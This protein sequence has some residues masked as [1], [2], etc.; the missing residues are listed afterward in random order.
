MNSSYESNHA[1]RS[2]ESSPRTSIATSGIAPIPRGIITRTE[3]TPLTTRYE[4]PKQAPRNETIPRAYPTSSR[5]EATASRAP[6]IPIDTETPQSPGRPKPTALNACENQFSSRAKRAAM[7]ALIAD[8]TI[9]RINR[10]SE[11]SSA[12]IL[13]DPRSNPPVIACIPIHRLDAATPRAARLPD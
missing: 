4:P 8:T 9:S 1:I 7:V 5:L 2:P 13:R 12:R 11:S 3:S 10:R 6:T